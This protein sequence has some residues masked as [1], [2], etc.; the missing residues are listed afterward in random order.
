MDISL[1]F[2]AN[3]LFFFFSCAHSADLAQHW[4]VKAG[5]TA[6]RRVRK[7]DNNRIARATGATIVSTPSEIKESDVGT[8]AG[9]FEV[10]K[11]GDE[12]VDA[13]SDP[14]AL[15]VSGPSW[16]FFIVSFRLLVC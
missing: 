13:T 2:S 12:Y 5:I 11:I 3:G 8:L 6:I 9:L 15:A 1:E 16:L 14:S 10:K 7:S 4:F